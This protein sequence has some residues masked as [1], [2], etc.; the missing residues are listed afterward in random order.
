[1]SLLTNAV[2]LLGT[3]APISL[4]P[5]MPLGDQESIQKL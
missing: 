5:S 2:K 3:D 4:D 1:M